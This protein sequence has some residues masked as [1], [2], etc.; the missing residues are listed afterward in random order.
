MCLK[1]LSFSMNERGQEQCSLLYNNLFGPS[2][3]VFGDSSRQEI[4]VLVFCFYYMQGE[5]ILES[6][7]VI[8]G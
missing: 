1:G 6:A 8:R 2:H 7:S 4:N 5:G 3:M